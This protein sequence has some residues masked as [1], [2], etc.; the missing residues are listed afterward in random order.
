MTKQKKAI[1]VPRTKVQG[2]KKLTVGGKGKSGD[3][4]AIKKL[5]GGAVIKNGR[6]IPAGKTRAKIARVRSSI[7]PG[8]ILILLTSCYK[9]KRCI[10]LG[11][12]P[13]GLLLVTGPFLFN[14]VP[15]RRVNPAYVIA[16]SKKID[17]SKI[18]TAKYTDEYFN[19]NK[20]L[21]KKNKV[22]KQKQNESIF[23]SQGNES[24][25]ALPEQV[26]QEQNAVDTPI[27]NMIKK[28][29]MLS[30]YLKTRFSLSQ[31]NTYPH[32]LKF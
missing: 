7:T 11:V 18:D 10:C 6:K 31:C 19:K 9:G 23:I 1:R 8:T 12:L 24:K 14:G 15:L 4:T 26:K 27:I 17:V 20:E 21:K 25:T 32:Q 22:Q 5:K 30:Q 29:I 2:Y 28:D 13:S 3:R 16:T